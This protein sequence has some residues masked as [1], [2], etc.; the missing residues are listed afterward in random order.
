MSYSISCQSKEKAEQLAFELKAE[1]PEIVE[2]EEGYLL[3]S[4]KLH[5][6]GKMLYEMV[7]AGKY[8]TS[9]SPEYNYQFHFLIAK[10]K[11]GLDLKVTYTS[12]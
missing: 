3:V 10:Y 1:N 4:D 12:K 5:T 8:T 6:L 11:L 9:Y 7:R 2:Q